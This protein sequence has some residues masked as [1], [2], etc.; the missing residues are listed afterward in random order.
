MNAADIVNTIE[1]AMTAGKS[2][3]RVNLKDG[4][5]LTV[6][7]RGAIHGDTTRIA[8]AINDGVRAQAAAP[9]GI[10]R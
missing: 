7:I 4:R 1:D 9:Q 5:R 8:R 10:V 2:S 6:V 3:V